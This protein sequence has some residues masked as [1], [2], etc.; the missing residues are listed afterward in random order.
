MFSPVLLCALLVF[1]A[2][3]CPECG[4]VHGVTDPWPRQQVVQPQ[5]MTAE[6]GL[7][8]A[9]LRF[10]GA[11][12]CQSQLHPLFVQL[13]QQGARMQAAQGACGHPGF[14]GRFQQA[15]ASGLCN[16]AS[17]ISAESWPWQARSSMYELGWEMFKCW[18]QSPGHWRTASTRHRYFGASM[19]QGRNGTWYGCIIVG[20]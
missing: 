9:G 19:A 1:N 10:P 4:L 6:E 20:D 11:Q 7:V 2:Q 14:N 3:A 8:A 17:E 15:V 16:S 5:A 13:A 12:V 18:R